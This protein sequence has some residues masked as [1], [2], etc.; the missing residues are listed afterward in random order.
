MPPYPSEPRAFIFRETEADSP[1]EIT[2]L[3]Q[4]FISKSPYL[5]RKCLTKTNTNRAI[6]LY[7]KSTIHC[8]AEIVQ[9]SLHFNQIPMNR[10]QH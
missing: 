9:F 10:E 4:F 6:D 7:P 5:E 8:T 2:H 1:K 3:N